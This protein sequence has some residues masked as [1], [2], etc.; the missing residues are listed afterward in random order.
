MN[1]FTVM[2]KKEALHISRELKIFWLP[3]IF[4]VLGMT[5]PVIMYY[6]PT[7]LQSMGGGQGIII[8]PNAAVQTAGKVLAGTLGSQFDQLGIMILVLSLMAIVQ[9]DKASGMLDMAMSRPVSPTSYVAA[10]MTANYVLAAGSIVAGYSCSYA[11]T[12]FLF[13]AV[14]WNVAMGALGSYLVWVFFIAAFTL[15]M[16]TILNNPSVIA[17]SSIVILLLC[18][19]TVGINDSLDRLN[20]ASVSYYSAQWLTTGAVDASAAGAAAI[21]IALS[22][23]CLLT[24]VFWI[25]EKKYQQS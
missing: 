2:A 4:I 21:S 24:A 11:Y 14:P 16:S 7:I 19:A 22:V 5:Q 23:C 18:R 8:D 17:L 15:A 20:P 3:I 13:E 6:L 10:K 1:S 12:Y 25:R 9:G